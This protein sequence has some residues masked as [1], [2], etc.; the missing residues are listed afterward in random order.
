MSYF[1]LSLYKLMSYFSLSLLFSFAETNMLNKVKNVSRVVIKIKVFFF[2]GAEGDY[3][4]TKNMIIQDN[5]SE[6]LTC[7]NC[8]PVTLN[9]TPVSLDVTQVSLK[10]I[11]LQP[12]Q[13]SR[14]GRET[15]EFRT[16]LS[17]H[18]I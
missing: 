6:S 4:G 13:L 11:R 3:T 8:P 12:F 7:R 17:S 9:I 18:A 10:M 15:H 2:C 14:F 16:H 5:C 1:S